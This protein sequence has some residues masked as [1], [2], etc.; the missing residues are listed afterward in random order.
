[1]SANSSAFW[2]S[3]VLAKQGQTE[4]LTIFSERFFQRSSPMALYCFTLAAI[5]REVCGRVEEKSE[6]GSAFRRVAAS[7]GHMK[8]IRTTSNNI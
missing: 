3:Q 6:E 4:A 7:R 5:F 8:G 1:V 2:K